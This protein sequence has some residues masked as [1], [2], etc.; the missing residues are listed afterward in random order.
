MVNIRGF[1]G[2]YEETGSGTRLVGGRREERH[3]P[4]IQH[5]QNFQR[6]FFLTNVW[7]V[8]IARINATDDRK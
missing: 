1:L 5:S 2:R 8:W 3:A 4:I 6:D 7:I